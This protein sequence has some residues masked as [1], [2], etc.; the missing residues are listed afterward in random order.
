[1]GNVTQASSF[2]MK[3]KVK[4]KAAVT[5]RSEKRRKI[6]RFANLMDLCNLKNSEVGRASRAKSKWLVVQHKMLQYSQ[7]T[8]A[9]GHTMEHVW[10]GLPTQMHP[11]GTSRITSAKPWVAWSQVSQFGTT[12][13]GVLDARTRTKKRSNASIMG[14]IQEGRLAAGEKSLPNAPP[15]ACIV[16]NHVVN[17]ARELSTVADLI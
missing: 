11:H 4:S 16:A 6:L 9:K 12:C 10:Q 14:Q 1:M 13:N 15:H 5:P 3:Q 2:G 17:R 8:P 7:R